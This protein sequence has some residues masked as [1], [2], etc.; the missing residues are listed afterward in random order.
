MNPSE[1]SLFLFCGR[2][3]TPIKALYHEPDGFILIYK[4]LS[5]K[6]VHQ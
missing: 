1:N 6:G 3:R 2:R 5:V 4:R